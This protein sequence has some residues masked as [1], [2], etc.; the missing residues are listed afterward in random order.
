MLIYKQSKYREVAGG[1]PKVNLP[2]PNLC[3]LDSF[4]I[5]YFYPSNSKEL[6][7]PLEILLEIIKLTLPSLVVFITVYVVVKQMTEQLLVT[8]HADQK[9]ERMKA[10]ISLRLQAYER[11]SLYC[12]RIRI[13]N[14]L[15][16]LQ[17]QHMTVASL[18]WAMLQAIQQEFEHNITQQIYVSES[19]WQIL[20]LARDHTMEVVDQVASQMPAEAAPDA[21][22]QAL[23]AF[24]E[25]Q[26]KDSLLTALSAIKKEAALQL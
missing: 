18:K 8:K 21:Y 9:V 10:T 26:E 2:I 12:E 19:L 13:P 1:N 5:M 22:V 23:F 16:R 14:L 11:L 3:I 7:T 24:L 4:A 6:M 15:L 20:K 25:K 17:T